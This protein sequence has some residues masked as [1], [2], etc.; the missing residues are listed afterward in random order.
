MCYLR[1]IGLELFTRD[2]GIYSFNL[3]LLVA[4]LANKN[5]ARKLENDWHNGSHL[6]VLSESYVMNTSMLRWFIYDGD[7]WVLY[8]RYLVAGK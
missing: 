4:N 2:W 7:I 5:D 1:R 8:L 3:M 6:G